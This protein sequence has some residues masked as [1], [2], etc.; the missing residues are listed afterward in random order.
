V[1]NTLTIT[2]KEF[3]SYMGSP[4]AYIVIGIFL[5]LTGFFFGNSSATYSTTSISGFLEVGSLLLLLLMAVLTMRLLAEERKLG[6]IELLLTSPVRDCEIILGKFLGSLGIITVMLVLT[7]YYPILL[8]V[9]GD[10][11]IGPIATGY[12]GL[13]LLSCA[14]LAIGIFASSLTSNQIVA[15][16]VTGG[17]LFGLWFLGSAV[18]Y[19]PRTLGDV[20]GY[21]SLSSYFQDFVIGII[22]TRGI[23]YYLSITALFLFLAIRSLVQFLKVDS[24]GNITGVPAAHAFTS[25]ILVVLGGVYFAVSR[26]E[27][28][29]PAQPKVYVWNVD[30]DEIEHVVISLPRQNLSQAFI[31]ISQGD[32]F[33]W[34]FDDAQRSPVNKTRWGGGI[35][36]LLSGPG[37]SRVITENA[38]AEQ[39][40]EYGLAEPSMLI[41]LTLGDGTIV[42]TEIGDKTP[43]GQN[44]YVRAPNS[45]AVA[46]VDYTWYDVLAALVTDPPYVSTVE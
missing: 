5:A 3:K 30:M 38:T 24:S 40:A 19:L 17:I 46:I 12:L 42:E 25:A 10:P 14:S 22:D 21:F 15:A 20:I 2:A 37:A 34:F 44:C 35:P 36:L 8:K 43:N 26:P 16:V 31:K 13:F 23:V 32:Q 41:T 6:T 4:M 1:R 33:P 29:E 7:S 11:D 9:F 28:E 39:L 18:D 45:N 27:P